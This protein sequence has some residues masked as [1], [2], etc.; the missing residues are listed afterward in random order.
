MAENGK[1]RPVLRFGVLAV[2]SMLL[3]AALVLLCIF[4]AA[5]SYTEMYLHQNLLTMPNLKF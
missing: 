3:L 1:K 5:P 4:G 2:L